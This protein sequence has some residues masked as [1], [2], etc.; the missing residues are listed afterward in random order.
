MMTVQKLRKMWHDVMGI[1]G[2]TKEGMGD[3][4]LWRIAQ[5][6][7]RLLITTDKG[8]SQHRN[9][10]HYGMII[11]CLRKPNQ[12]RIHHRIMQAINQ[13]DEKEWRGLLVVMRDKVQSAWKAQS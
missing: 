12:H 13:I 10:S 5:K 4:A 3:E 11:V 9:K 1:R 6:E 2:T 7:G 8:F